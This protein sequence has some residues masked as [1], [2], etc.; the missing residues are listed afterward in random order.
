ME[1]LNL[2]ELFAAANVIGNR[3]EV[4]DCDKEIIAAI[5]DANA[6]IE[7]VIESMGMYFD[8]EIQEWVD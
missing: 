1:S 5:A 7:A 3:Y 6:E 8:P 4:T 2:S